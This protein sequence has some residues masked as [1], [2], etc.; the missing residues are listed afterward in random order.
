M[1]VVDVCTLRVPSRSKMSGGSP[2]CWSVIAANDRHV[3][4]A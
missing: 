3:P 1:F 2:L 4:S